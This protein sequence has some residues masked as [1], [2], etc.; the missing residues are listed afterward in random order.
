VTETPSNICFIQEETNYGPFF[1]S[2]GKAEDYLRARLTED[3]TEEEKAELAK[4]LAGTSY[5]VS[6]VE[7][8]LDNEDVSFD[9]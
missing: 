1:S 6:I 4:Q 8:E 9:G 5:Y 2:R 7:V 3:A